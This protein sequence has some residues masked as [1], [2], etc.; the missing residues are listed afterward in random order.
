MQILDADPRDRRGTR[1]RQAMLSVLRGLGASEDGASLKKRIAD[2]TADVAAAQTMVDAARAKTARDAAG[3]PAWT[4]GGADIVP[5]DLPDNWT[6]GDAAG[7][8]FNGVRSAIYGIVNSG[9]VRGALRAVNTSGE[10]AGT[11]IAAWIWSRLYSRDGWPDD[12]LIGSLQR[13]EGGD[14][15]E[16]LYFIN[17]YSWWASGGGAGDSPE[18]LVAVMADPIATL[19]AVDKPGRRWG[20]ALADIAGAAVR[21]VKWATTTRENDIKDAEDALSLAKARLEDARAAAQ[22]GGFSD[23]GEK[24]DDSSDCLPGYKLNADTGKCEKEEEKSVLPWVLGG[25]AVLAAVLFLRRR[26]P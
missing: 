12:N 8:D 23:T 17:A 3:V 15:D 18:R 13:R 16:Q 19:G 22:E 6:T 5:T 4:A 9:N 11:R 24:A 26:S 10:P 7:L 1:A 25:A 20:S 21:W 14:E 2:A